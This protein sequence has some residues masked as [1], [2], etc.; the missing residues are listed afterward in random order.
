MYAGKHPHRHAFPGMLTL[1]SLFPHPAVC[2]RGR[3]PPSLRWPIHI[4]IKAV[5]HKHIWGNTHRIMHQC[6]C[7]RTSSSVS[8]PLVTLWFPPLLPPPTGNLLYNLT[9]VSVRLCAST[10]N[11]QNT[12]WVW[13]L[14]LYWLCCR[15]RVE[16]YMH[17]EITVSMCAERER[18]T[19]Q[20]R[21]EVHYVESAVNY[22]GLIFTHSSLC[23]WCPLST[24]LVGFGCI[25]VCP[26]PPHHLLGPPDCN[27]SP[28]LPPL[29][30]QASLHAVHS[31]SAIS[32]CHS[33][34]PFS[35]RRDWKKS[36][37][38]KQTEIWTLMGGEIESI[39]CQG[40]QTR[41]RAITPTHT[42]VPVLF[43]CLK[44]RKPPSYLITSIS[45]NL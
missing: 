43:R 1:F 22:A 18:K 26:L 4:T 2:L 14:S 30:M 10:V 39:D 7:M 21:S 20:Q 8:Q 13:K 45:W 36:N 33:L 37:T 42:P 6:I 9:V 19:K 41:R 44:W 32:K 12:K 34:L 17:L 40:M 38:C 31:L 35:Y 5:P 29:R 23:L 16:L 24:A 3:L 11:G 27:R 28:S 15:N 25:L